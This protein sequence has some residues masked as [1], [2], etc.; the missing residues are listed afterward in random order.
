MNEWKKL[1]N[2]IDDYKLNKGTKKIKKVNEKISKIIN[3]L[4]SESYI[5]YSCHKLYSKTDMLDNDINDINNLLNKV[6][7]K[8]ENEIENITSNNTEPTIKAQEEL[9]S[10]YIDMN[11]NY[12]ENQE[13]IRKAKIEYDNLIAGFNKKNLTK[14]ITP[15]EEKYVKFLGIKIF[16]AEK[17]L[18]KSYKNNSDRFNS[19]KNKLNAKYISQNVSNIHKNN[20]EKKEEKQ[21][22]GLVKHK[23]GIIQRLGAFAAA[24]LIGLGSTAPNDK[25]DNSKK[26]EKIINGNSI[27][28]NLDAVEE[29]KEKIDV[30]TF[31]E[32]NIDLE[33][34]NEVKNTDEKQEQILKVKGTW[35]NKSLE[36]GEVL[37]FQKG[38]K[39]LEGI[40][41]GNFGEIGN[42]MSPEDAFYIIDRVAKRTDEG[43]VNEYRLDGKIADDSKQ[44][45]H[46]SLIKGAKTVEEAYKILNEQKGKEKVD[47][48]VICARGWLKYDDALNNSE[49]S[50]QKMMNIDEEER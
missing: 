31:I 42:S 36:C 1:S 10:L 13:T 38:M 2:L 49:K 40:D 43:I 4:K 25:T 47:N 35:V 21:E 37:K 45:V 32:K 50:F 48:E 11:K 8:Y 12:E 15:E 33:K 27:S 3:K 22:L 16:D 28:S 5:M 46:I 20:E 29:T 24:M 9:K 26:N 6:L 41:G 23:K 30:V 34:E 39:F 18:D 17:N 19:L 7:D 14:E 44:L